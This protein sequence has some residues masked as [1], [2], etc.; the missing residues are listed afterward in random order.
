MSEQDPMAPSEDAPHMENMNLATLLLTGLLSSMTVADSDAGKQA[1]AAA[2]VAEAR[3]TVGSERFEPEE[4]STEQEIRQLRQE[5]GQPQ[6]DQR[7]EI[8]PR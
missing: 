5:E 7:L 1:P 2:P 4:E 3:S 6:D 8:N